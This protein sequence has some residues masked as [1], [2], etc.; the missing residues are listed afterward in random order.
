MEDLVSVIIPTYGDGQF[1]SRAVDSV[2]AQTYQFIEIIVV[3]DNGLGTPN[4][5]STSQVMK[6][7]MNNAKIKYICHE[8]NRNGSAAR[9]TGVNN[10]NGDYIALLDDDDEFLPSKIER[11]LS[12]LLSQPDSCGAVYC[13]HE[14][15]LNGEKVGEE[16]ATLSGKILYEYMSHKVEIASSALLLK[17]TVYDELGGFDETFKRHQDWEFI[18]R[19]LCKYEIKADDFWGFKRILVFRNSAP[20]PDVL[21][22]RRLYY[23]ERI[24]PV[25]ATLPEEQQQYI[26]LKEKVDIALAYV[27]NKQYSAFLRE[28]FSVKPR[29][30]GLILL[31]HRFLSFL[32]RGGKLI[33]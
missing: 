32:R 11:Q 23:L 3:D 6:K 27:K 14:T 22:E 25:L 20:N 15:F 8:I 1:L 13:S 17:K 4:Q 16:H 31:F 10:S 18:S 29:I 7:Y 28:T 24:K 33:K 12:L 9:N 5:L 30:K 2:L 19:M 21:K 26:I